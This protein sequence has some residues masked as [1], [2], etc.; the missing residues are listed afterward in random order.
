[1]TKHF[2]MKNIISLHLLNSLVPEG[3]LLIE[4]IENP[5]ISNKPLSLL[6]YKLRRVMEV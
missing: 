4:Y 6:S 2:G 1:M 5:I 3:T